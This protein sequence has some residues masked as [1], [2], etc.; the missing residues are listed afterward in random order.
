MVA[1]VNVKCLMF[2][3]S[4]LNQVSQM[5]TKANAKFGTT[6]TSVNFH[7]CDIQNE[8]LSD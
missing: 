5:L 2:E 4:N 1:N 6:E 3:F 7:F 8:R